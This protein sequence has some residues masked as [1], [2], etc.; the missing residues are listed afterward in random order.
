MRYE[1]TQAER[2][3]L[4]LLWEQSRRSAAQLAEALHSE[5]GWTQQT[6]R[7]LLRRMRQKELVEMEESGGT[8]R[9]VCRLARGQVTTVQP[10]FEIKPA[11][12]FLRLAAKGGKHQ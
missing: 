6:V 5:T 11:E 1:C 3:I 2:R 10:W 7:A 8:E 9:Y 12:R 4:E